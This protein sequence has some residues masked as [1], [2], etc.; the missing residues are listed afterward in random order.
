[1]DKID[2]LKRTD[3]FAG[4]DDSLAARLGELAVMRGME[5]GEILFHSGEKAKGLFAVVSGKVRI[6]R[7]SPAGKE[8]I[9]HVFGPG[10]AFAEVPMFQGTDYPASA[11]ALTR[12]KVLFFSR[13]GFCRMIERHPDLAMATLGLLAGRLR[14]LVSQVSALSLKEVPARLATYLLLLQS[15]Q[16]TRELELDLPKGQIA[17]YLGTI[18]ETLSRILKKMCE[19]GLIAMNGKRITILDHDRLALL[20][21]GE[22][23]L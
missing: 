10:R 19:A 21:E 23:Q 7:S 20:A 5:K 14:S 9:I 18:Q 12:G 17:A 6:Y 11:Q 15:S 13:D 3:I 2:A 1:M 8:Q 16:L 4:I 22:E